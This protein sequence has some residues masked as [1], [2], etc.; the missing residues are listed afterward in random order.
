M[1]RSIISLAGLILFFNLLGCAAVQPAKSPAEMATLPEPRL[2]LGP[3]DVLEVKFFYN[4]EL[5]ESQTVRPDGKIALQLIGEV[6]VR[7]KTP[8][9][10]KEE[11]VKAYTGQLRIAEVA[12]IVRSFINRRVYVGGDV[13]RPGV[14]EMPRRITAL[15][16]IMMAGGF[17]YR[18]AEVSNVVIIR[19]KDGKRYGC[20]LDF[21]DALKGKEFQ[22]FY[23]EPEDIIYVPRTVISKVNLWID[24][25]INQIIP[26]VGFTYSTLLGSGAT[27]G[28]TPPTTV[29]TQP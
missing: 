29:V 8:S 1:G 21:R 9:E 23:L 22:P 11:L 12:V 27:I 5:N 10:L 17:D 19:H 16:A 2:T 25:Y 4:P 28:F 24:Q 15:E 7:E 26:R 3:G 13:T 20:S 18:R 6:D 14:I